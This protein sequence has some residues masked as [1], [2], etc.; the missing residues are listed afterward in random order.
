MAVGKIETAER[1]IAETP[2]GTFMIAAALI[3]AAAVGIAYWSERAYL[4]WW[5]ANHPFAEP[6]ARIERMR[7]TYRERR[8][9]LAEVVQVI[10]EV[11]ADISREPEHDGSSPGSSEARRDD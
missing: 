5:E 2:P 7:A 3:L 4:R 1:P 6:K 8:A 10:W 11:F 9:N